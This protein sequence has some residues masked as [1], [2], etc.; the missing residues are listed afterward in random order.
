[1]AQSRPETSKKKAAVK[2]GRTKEIAGVSI[3]AAAGA[4][5]GTREVFMSCFSAVSA[6]D[7]KIAQP[8][9]SN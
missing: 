8:S 3:D 9:K 4:A 2:R 6:F 1:V 5:G 7:G